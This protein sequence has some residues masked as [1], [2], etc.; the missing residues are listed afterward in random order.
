MSRESIQ[1]IQE[2][3]ARAEKLVEDAKRDARTMQADAERFGKEECERIEA[4]TVAS[5][6]AMMEQLRERTDAMSERMNA[7]A[8]EEAEK[9]RSESALRHRSVEKIVIRGLMS[10][11]R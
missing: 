6:A 7:E 1:K 9:L 3:E 2:A 5:L 8:Q 4:E 11:C 10:K